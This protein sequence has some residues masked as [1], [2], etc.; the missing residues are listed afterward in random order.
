VPLAWRQGEN[1]AVFHSRALRSAVFSRAGRCGAVPWA[2]GLM[3][4][5]RPAA[6]RRQIYLA[7]KV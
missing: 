3:A 6:Q 2:A 4:R 1:L 7:R 5:S